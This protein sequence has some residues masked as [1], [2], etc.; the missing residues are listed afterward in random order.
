MIAQNLLSAE[1][2]RDYRELGIQDKFDSL[3]RNRAYGQVAIAPTT[4]WNRLNLL[5]CLDLA[6]QVGT[7]YP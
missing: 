5:N 4:Y 7:W 2:T 6:Q 1:E 3:A